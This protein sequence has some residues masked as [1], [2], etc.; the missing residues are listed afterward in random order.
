MTTAATRDHD[1]I[2]RWAER[3]GAQP[4]TGEPSAKGS[5]S[6]DVNDGDAGIRF[7]F[8]GLG[9]YREISWSEWF[10]NFE[11]YDLAFVYERDRP[12]YPLTNRYRLV[13]TSTLDAAVTLV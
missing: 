6:F 5:S 13:P 7:N 9:R 8:P 2:R 4:A 1:L 12:G 11:Q 3:H 10:D